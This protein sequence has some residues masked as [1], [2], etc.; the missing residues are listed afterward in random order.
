M[1]KVKNVTKYYPSRYGKQYVFRDL[2]LDLPC[3]RDIAL[4]GENGSG[5]STLLRLIGGIDFPNGGRI[6]RN[7]YLSWPLALSRGFQGSMT[8]RENVRFVCR[9]HGV[10]DTRAIEDYVEDFS[11]LGKKLDL[12]FKGYSSGMRSK[13]S[14]AVS[15]A[16]DFDTYLLDEILA[17]GDDR[18]KEKCHQALSNKRQ[19]ANIILVSH[20]KRRIRE[21]CNAGVV[22]YKGGAEFFND[23]EEAL[24][25]YEAL[26]G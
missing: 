9:I 18:F 22:L 26:C 17:V 2:T 1:I 16:F 10:R 24:D 21:N 5:K 19:S 14:F 7:R 4:L 6:E 15:M 13:F 25:R 23:V 12:P 3:D 20:Q 11:E 8:G